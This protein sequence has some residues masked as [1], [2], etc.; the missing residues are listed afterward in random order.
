MNEPKPPLDLCVSIIARNAQRTIQRTICSV[1]GLARRVIVV[2]SGST[3]A[4]PDICRGLGS[5]VVHHEWEG[6]GQQKRFAL[7]LCDA[8]W[9]LCLDSDESPDDPLANEIRRVVTADD[10]AVNGYAMNRRV[11]LGDIELRHTWQ[12]EWKVRLV[13]RN[14]AQ[15]VGN[16][17]ER[18]EVKGRV[19]RLRGILRHDAVTNVTDLVEKQALHGVQAAE[20]YYGLGVRSN[21]LKLLI[22]PPAAV[23]KQLVLHSAWRDGW[24]GWVAAF[25]T[26]INAAAKHMRLLELSHRSR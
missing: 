12:P 6:Y 1:N 4:T 19:E 15:W 26:G 23:L 17:H 20:E 3:D 10:Q 2:D 18:L 25:G 11:W 22:S 24:V 16:Y 8:T 7:G 9:A 5:E 13:R 14:A 21:A